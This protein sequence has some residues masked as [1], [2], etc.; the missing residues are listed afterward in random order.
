MSK[1]EKFLDSKD[2]KEKYIDSLTSTDK[3]YPLFIRLILFLLFLGICG[4][5]FY[6]FVF[7]RSPQ[8]YI[9]RYVSNIVD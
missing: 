3:D 4:V 6:L 1:W 2:S 9:M 8:Y 5:L 7:D